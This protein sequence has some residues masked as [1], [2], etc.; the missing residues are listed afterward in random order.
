MTNREVAYIPMFKISMFK[1]VKLNKHHF[2]FGGKHD[3]LIPLISPRKK[4][5]NKK[6]VQNVKVI[7]KKN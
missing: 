5:I 2:I 6:N 4:K 3:N 7:F 1:L